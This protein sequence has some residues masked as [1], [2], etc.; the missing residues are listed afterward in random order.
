MENSAQG[1]IAGWMDEG[2]FRRV[3]RDRYFGVHP[4]KPEKCSPFDEV[5]GSPSQADPKPIRAKTGEEKGEKSVRANPYVIS[6]RRKVFRVETQ[7][8]RISLNFLPAAFSRDSENCR[9]VATAL[10]IGRY[11]IL[12]IQNFY[13]VI[14]SKMRPEERGAADRVTAMHDALDLP[15]ERGGSERRTASNSFL[16]TVEWRVGRGTKRTREPQEME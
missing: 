13:S 10:S 8:E 16:L 1:E 6:D 7:A 15:Q 9:H 11:S 5:R 2:E 4:G 12:R 3:K 14:K